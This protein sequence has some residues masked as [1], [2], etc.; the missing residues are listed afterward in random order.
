[1]RT[2]SKTGLLAIVAAL[3]LMA[4]R[5]VAARDVKRCG[6]TI[7]AGKTGTIVKD[8]TCGYHC[9]ADPTTSCVVENLGDDPTCPIS[10]D[11]SCAPDAITL[12]KNATLDLNGFRFTP[13]YQEATGIV[14]APG[15]R[16]RCTIVGP[17]S[18]FGGKQPSIEANDMDLVLKDLT[19]QR[20]YKQIVVKHRLHLDNVVVDH[21][22]GFHA[23][24]GVRARN[25][26]IQDESGLS[27]GRDF[28][29]DGLTLRDG[30]IEALG[31]MRVRN[32]TIVYGSH[33][34]GRDVFVANSDVVS[35]YPDDPPSGI[36]IRADR[37]L[38]V[39]GSDVTG[40][41]SGDAPKLV[42][43]TCVQSRQADGVSSW[44]VC[45]NDN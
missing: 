39:R 21:L 15:R 30:A 2:Q 10:A 8:V 23:E 13:A 6:I 7:S 34:R 44:G 11:Q 27:S 37:R 1:M 12:E 29:A 14:C 17:G 25:V 24:Q 26:T 33:V 35:S 43:S 18:I 5:V 32:S 16:G 19:V 9:V 36:E 3:T 42:G 41:Q 4:P 45:T 22:V 28:Q 38:V 40:I 20:M 31:N